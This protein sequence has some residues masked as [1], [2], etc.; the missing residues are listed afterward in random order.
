MQKTTT[1]NSKRVTAKQIINAKTGT[2]N[3]GDNIST[4]AGV[5]VVWNYRTSYNADGTL[6]SFGR[7]TVCNAADADLIAIVSSGGYGP[8]LAL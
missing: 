2:T 3:G 6:K 1:I 5:E 8:E 4:I 7:S